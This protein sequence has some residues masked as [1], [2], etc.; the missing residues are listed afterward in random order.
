MSVPETDFTFQIT[1]PT[2][3]F[4]GMVVKPWAERKRTVFQ[5]MPEVQ[6]KL[7]AIPGI[8]IFPVTPPALPVAASS[9]WNSSWL[10]PPETEQILEF[11]KKIQMKAMQSGMFA[12][13][14][15]IDVKIDQPQTRVRHRPRQGRLHGTQPGTDRRRYGGDGGR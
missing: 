1:F 9:R 4:G 5:I 14:P 6:Q 7:Q 12:F 2:S 3:G 13:P 11:A 15:M 8:Q 10:P